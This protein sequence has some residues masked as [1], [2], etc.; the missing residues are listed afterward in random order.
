MSIRKTNNLKELEQKFKN[1][2]ILTEVL[3]ENE[4]N[5]PIRVR[6]IAHKKDRDSLN[7][8]LKRTK[9]KH[10]YHFFNGPPLKKG[11]AAAFYVSQ[12]EN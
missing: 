2:W 9:A 6:L 11:Y 7:N 8:A 4:L 10:T 1:E 12:D 3:E 5:E